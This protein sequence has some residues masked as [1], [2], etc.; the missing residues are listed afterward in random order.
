MLAKETL[1]ALFHDLVRDAMATQQVPVVGD[2]RVL[3]GPAARRRS[4]APDESDLLDPPL[5]VDYLEAFHLPGVAAVRAAEAR[6]RHGAV[7]DRRLRRQPRAEPRRARSTTRR[8]AGPPTRGSRRCRRAR[9]SARCS[10]SW[11]DGSRSSCACWR[12]SASTSSSGASRTRCGSTSAGCR[13]GGA[14]EADMLDAA[15]AHPFA[16]PTIRSTDRATSTP[17]LDRYG[18]AGDSGCAA[19]P[20][21][22][23]GAAFA[24][25]ATTIV[26]SERGDVFHC[27]STCR[28]PFRRCRTCC[29]VVQPSRRVIGSSRAGDAREPGTRAAEVVDDRDDAAGAAHALRLGDQARARPAPR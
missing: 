29:D 2:D 10:A 23:L 13:R 4:R 26:N 11:P 7:R 28:A 16:P 21:S 8:S 17:E 25:R 9:R 20:R 14:R 22:P 1:T 18:A 19:T 15:R 24:L 3:P 12:R 6:R 5:G 27:R